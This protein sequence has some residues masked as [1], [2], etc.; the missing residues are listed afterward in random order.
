MIDAAKPEMPAVGGRVAWTNPFLAFART[1]DG[2]DQVVVTD[3]DGDGEIVLTGL[4][5]GGARVLA[6]GWSP[7]RTRVAFLSDF[8]AD[9]STYRTNVFVAGLDP[10]TCFMSTP[11]AAE[12]VVGQGVVLRLQGFLKGATGGGGALVAVPDATVGST[13]GGDTVKTNQGGG[14]VIDLPGGD[15]TLVFRRV[16]RDAAGNEDYWG[17]VVPYLAAGG[18]QQSKDAVGRQSGGNTRI[19]AFTWKPDGTG[20]SVVVSGKRLGVAGKDEAF[21]ELSEYDAATGAFVSLALPADLTGVRRLLPPIV[22]SGGVRVLPWVH[23]D[24]SGKLTFVFGPG[25]DG[26]KTIPAPGLFWDDATRTGSRVVVSPADYLAW[27]TDDGRLALL[28]ADEAGQ[29]EQESRDAFPGLIVVPDEL[30][31]SPDGLRVV[32]TTR[33]GD[34]VDLYVVD[35]NTLEGRALTTDGASHAPAWYGR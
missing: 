29:L 26:S 12:G 1:V 25:E 15:G 14:Y 33:K 32:V 2:V 4:E 3:P 31:W 20:F 10:L 11:N 34:A 18:M 23:Q 7:D 5:Q 24:H 8:W 22:L 6:T 27:V 28:G 9:H 35:V 19:D 17:A 30:D 21:T 16:A 13:R